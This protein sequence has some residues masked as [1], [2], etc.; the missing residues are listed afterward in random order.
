MLHT[1]ILDPEQSYQPRPHFWTQ[2]WL[3]LPISETQVQISSTQGPTNP[4][5]KCLP[6]SEA[7][8]EYCP[9]GRALQGTGGRS[10][11]QKGKLSI[12]LFIPVEKEWWHCDGDAVHGDFTVQP[13]CQCVHCGR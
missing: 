4:E 1:K 12:H 11:G 7:R 6:I 9:N 5:E 2:G 8:T 10:S 13:V 3:T